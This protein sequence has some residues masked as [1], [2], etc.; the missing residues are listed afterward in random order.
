MEEKEE[1]EE[2]RKVRGCCCE[3]CCSWAWSV[4][5]RA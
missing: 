3:A 4:E 1:G 2:G 5:M